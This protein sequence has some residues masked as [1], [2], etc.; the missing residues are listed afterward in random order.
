MTQPYPLHWPSTHPRTPA[1]ERKRAQF[2]KT[3]LL[4]GQKWATKRELTIA[5]ARSRLIYELDMLGAE[6]EVLSTNVE[7]RLDGMPRS[8][9]RP[10]DDPGAV[11]YFKLEGMD[12]ALPCDK[13]DRVAD[14]I[15][16]IAKH[17]EAM[18]G[19]DRWGV[20]SVRQ[21]FTGYQAL[22]AP[23]Q[24]WETLGVTS[25]ATLAEIDDAYRAKAKT[26]PPDNGG[27]DADMARLNWARDEG[28]RANG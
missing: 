6:D 10:H 7:L 12:I 28:R 18:R 27:T 13:W 23:E 8:D 22:P 3:A 5:D 11:S 1:S 21:A 2:G 16:A 25:R 9:R 19:M 17:V 4:A 20:G 26:A 14:N 15:A 24:W